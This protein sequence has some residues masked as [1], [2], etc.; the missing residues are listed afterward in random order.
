MPQRK[1][2]AQIRSD[3][4]NEY[5]YVDRVVTFYLGRIIRLFRKL[6]AKKFKRNRDFIIYIDDFYEDLY[7]LCLE[8]YESIAKKYGEKSMDKKWVEKVLKTYDP[9]TLYRFDHELER[10]KGRHLEAVIASDNPDKEHDNALKYF[11]NMFKQYGDIVADTAHIQ[12]MKDEGEEMVVW[13]S[14]NDNRRCRT[15]KERDGKIYPINK[16]PTKPHIGCRCWVE[17]W[18]KQ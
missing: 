17:A 8:A 1:T 2:M 16:I 12:S 6:K 18:K 15:C 13:I 3:E 7:F 11:S 5:Q 9:V 10:K 14:V 4:L